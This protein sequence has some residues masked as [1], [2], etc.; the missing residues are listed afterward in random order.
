MDWLWQV[1]VAVP[2]LL[3]QTLQMLPVQHS[4]VLYGSLSLLV[5]LVLP[6]EVC[7]GSAAWGMTRWHHCQGGKGTARACGWD[8]ENHPGVTEG[9][10]G[11]LKWEG[12]GVWFDVMKEWSVINEGGVAVQWG[13]EL[14][15]SIVWK[16]ASPKRLLS[17]ARLV[18]E[19]L[20]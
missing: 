5:P 7:Q 6:W 19:R 14:L 10:C 16:A 2:S 20:G 8:M 4:Q 9:G 11:L 17:A 18:L 3:A 1:R 13:T 15:Y 12:T